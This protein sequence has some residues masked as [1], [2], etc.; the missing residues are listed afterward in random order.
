MTVWAI[1]EILAINRREGDWVKKAAP[2]WGAE[3]VTLLI[4]IVVVAVVVLIHPWIG[5]VPVW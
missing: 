1:I 2:S 4:A 5:G 3:L